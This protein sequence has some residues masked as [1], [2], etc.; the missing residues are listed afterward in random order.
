MKR[1]SSFLT[2]LLIVFTISG[3]KSIF[4]IKLGGQASQNRNDATSDLLNVESLPGMNKSGLS[5]TELELYY[6]LN[7]S[8]GIELY[9]WENKGNIYCGIMSG[10]NRNK[11]DIEIDNIK[12]HPAT[13]EQMKSI[14]QTY[15][16]VE[17]IIMLNETKVLNE[18]IYK[19][20]DIK[21]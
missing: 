12:K 21:Y 18:D 9:V 4:Y 3:C 7:F 6:N 5:K 2:I 15:D 16:K 14:L 10:T 19:A 13:L 20:L 17:I 1:I 11:T 8:K